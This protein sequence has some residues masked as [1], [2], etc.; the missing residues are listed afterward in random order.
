MNQPQDITTGWPEDASPIPFFK[1]GE[2]S[3]L[4]EYRLLKQIVGEVLCQQ[5]PH[6]IRMH[7]WMDNNGHPTGEIGISVLRMVG[8]NKSWADFHKAEG[9]YPPFLEPLRWPGPGDSFLMTVEEFF[10]RFHADRQ[11]KIY[12]DQSDLMDRAWF[13]IEKAVKQL[14]DVHLSAVDK[15]R[16]RIEFT[17]SNEH[18]IPGSLYANTHY[19]FR[20]LVIQVMEI[21]K[22]KMDKEAAEDSN[23]NAPLY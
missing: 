13:L 8:E 15:Y 18:I 5:H 4:E 1:A 20:H 22:K 10:N 3:E 7:A 19:L 16:S 21:L 2:L 12:V 6:V 17:G 14:Q 9:H 23:T 11:G